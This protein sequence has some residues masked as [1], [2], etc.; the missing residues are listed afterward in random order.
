MLKTEINDRCS[1]TRFVLFG[2]CYFSLTMLYVALYSNNFLN[3]NQR[4]GNHFCVL[5]NLLQHFLSML[6]FFFEKFSLN[7]NSVTVLRNVIKKIFSTS[8]TIWSLSCSE[9]RGFRGYNYD[10]LI[11]LSRRDSQRPSISL[12]TFLLK[13]ALLWN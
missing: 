12:N 11:C 10:F 1:E 6:F 5:T 3:F 7:S 9:F 8:I 2:A 4:N 13:P